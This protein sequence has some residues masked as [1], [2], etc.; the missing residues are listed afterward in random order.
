MLSW[1]LYLLLSFDVSQKR[2]TLRTDR[3]KQA[4]KNG[5]VSIAQCPWVI[6]FI[7]GYYGSLREHDIGKLLLRCDSVLEKFI[8]N[9]C[10]VIMIIFCPFCVRTEK[11][12]ER[13]E[14]IRSKEPQLRFILWASVLGTHALPTMLSLGPILSIFQI[15]NGVGVGQF[16]SNNIQFHE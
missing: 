6:Q 13:G 2:S 10:K 5:K 4:G 9:I 15:G 3:E 11:E 16:D 7:S 14:M 1:I 8:A 12:W